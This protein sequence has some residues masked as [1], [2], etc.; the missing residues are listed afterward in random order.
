LGFK[1][2]WNDG[3]GGQKMS[4]NKSQVFAIDLIIAL[5][6]FLSLLGIY[7]SWRDFVYSKNVGTRDFQDS[8]VKVSQAAFLLFESEGYPV[9]WNASTVQQLGLMK[10]RNTLHKNKL[11]SFLNLS[12]DNATRML[13]LGG[14]DWYFE[15]RYL[16][17]TMVNVSTVEWN[18]TVQKG[19]AYDN[20]SL[21]VPLRKL[22]LYE[23]QQA[24]ALLRLAK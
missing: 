4:R 7:S 22:V 2:V 8:A 24:V 5:V 13:G 19:F 23:G 1:P 16:N 21:Q 18:G 9:A 14:F 10:A 12:Y 3:A 20:Y 11:A 6:L 15:L 17:G